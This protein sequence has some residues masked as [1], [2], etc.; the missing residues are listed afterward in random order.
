MDFLQLRRLDSGELHCDQ[1]HIGDADKARLELVPESGEVVVFLHRG[2][3]FL[4]KPL[5]F[6][7]GLADFEAQGRLL[8]L[9]GREG[10]LTHLQLLAEVVQGSLIVLEFYCH[11]FNF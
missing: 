3:Q 2:I 6:L 7:L 5:R 10:L 11:T 8:V 4:N 9:K 1:I